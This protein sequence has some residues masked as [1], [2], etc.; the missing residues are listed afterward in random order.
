MLQPM[1]GCKV[2]LDAHLKP[3]N[4]LPVLTTTTPR[5]RCPKRRLQR[6]NGANFSAKGPSKSAEAS[7][8]WPSGTQSGNQKDGLWKKKNDAETNKSL[9]AFGE[10]LLDFVRFAGSWAPFGTPNIQ[11]VPKLR[12]LFGGY[13]T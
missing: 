6:T 4:T 7:F 5:R 10:S 8:I 2:I 3:P 12:N 9:T 13:L 11:G 1:Y